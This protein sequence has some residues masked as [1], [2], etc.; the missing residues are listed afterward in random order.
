MS[1]TFCEAIATAVRQVLSVRGPIAEDDLLAVLVADGI[2]LGPDPE[3][4]LTD[5]LDEDAEL[6]MPLADERWAWIPALLDGRIFTHLLSALE[7]EHDMIGFGPDL[8]PLSILTESQTYQRLTDGS[9]IADVSP[10]LDG[11]LLAARGVPGVV[12]GGGGRAQEGDWVARGGFDFGT[13]RV[14]GQI[15]TIAARYE[16]HDDE[17]LAVLAT[18][19]LYEQTAALVDAVTSA[20]QDGDAEEL[21]DIASQLFPPQLDPAPSNGDPALDPDRT[22]VRATLKFLAEPAVA[23]AMLA[24]TSADEERGAVA[25]GLFAES[26]EALVSRG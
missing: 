12:G 23:A 11:D 17:A 25:L 13:W 14:H 26:V 22:T 3:D 16:L 19:R 6:V 15:E 2:D 21:V 8:A 4:M 10:F 18:V 24:E 1:G 7:A 20:Q 5:I 9:P